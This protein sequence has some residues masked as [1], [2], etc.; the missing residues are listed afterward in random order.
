MV[1][2][3]R[4]KES[5][6]S[7]VEYVL[8]IGIV[9]SLVFLLMPF[10]P[11]YFERVQSYV[12]DRYKSSYRYGDPRAKGWDEGGPTSHVRADVAGGNNL[13]MFRRNK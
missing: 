12:G 9:V 1:I 13:R 4:R 2:N 10:L 6:Q 8:L 7:L 11:R 3:T 5:G